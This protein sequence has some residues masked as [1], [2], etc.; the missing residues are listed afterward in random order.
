MKNTFIAICMLC[1][2][3]SAQAQTMPDD[4]LT[5]YYELT[6]YEEPE[7]SQM[8]DKAIQ[9]NAKQPWYHLIKADFLQDIDPEAAEKEYIL[10]L[11]KDPNLSATNAFY[12]R[13]IQNNEPTQARLAK[14]M[15][16]TEKAIKMEPKE[17]NYLVD[18]ANILLLQKKYQA[19]FDQVEAFKKLDP[20]Y[21]SDAIEIQVRALV[22][23][24]N[25]DN[26]HKY[27]KATPKIMDIFF[28]DEDQAMM[29]GNIYLELNMQDNACTVFRKY[30]EVLEQVGEEFSN[31]LKTKLKS[32]K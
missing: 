16:M 3:L 19:A 4:I 20:F 10:A 1:L 13:F 21:I 11:Q 32:C 15:E 7:R 28:T 5:F 31:D 14:A 29:I 9:A 17:S 6:D 30:A 18:R 23:L 27:F 24:G 26:L 8:L 2:S 22:E 12:S 25:K